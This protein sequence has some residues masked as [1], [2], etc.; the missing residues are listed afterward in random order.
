[1]PPHFVYVGVLEKHKGLAPLLD[2]F[3]EADLDIELHV[4]GRGSMAQDVKRF[5]IS[6]D[7]KVVGRGH[8]SRDEVIPEVASATALIAPS[9]CQENSPLSCIEALALGVPLIVS[10]RGGL[11]EMVS[12]NNGIAVEP[13]AK[14]IAG[15]M[16]SIALDNDLRTVLI[17]VRFSVL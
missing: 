12:D 16:R 13:T 1:M 8:L 4:L 6:T 11:P 2:A 14:N 15:A 9:I 7:G 17:K 10:S 5:E 3:K